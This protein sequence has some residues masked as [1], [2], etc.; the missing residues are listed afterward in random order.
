[1]Q[2]DPDPRGKGDDSETYGLEPEAAAPAASRAPSPSTT[3]AARTPPLEDDDDSIDM[4]P[5]Q[6]GSGDGGEEDG[7]QD[8]G[9]SLPP[10]ISRP[11]APTPWLVAGGACVALVAISWLAGAEQLTLPVDGKYEELGFGARLAG[12]ART[13]V[14]TPIAT[15]GAV[16]GILGLAFMRQRPVGDV[17]AMFA[18]C[19]AIVTIPM[20]LWLVPTDVRFLKQLLNFA[21]YPLAAGALAVPLFRL[22]P[23]DA[24][25][26]T[27][28]SLVGMALVVLS[29]AVVVWAVGV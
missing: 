20:L 19:L 29:S 2:T 8:D 9:D 6:V 11:A 17:P 10:A 25:L 21:G 1:M 28:L 16:F 7:E 4:D 26:A 27:G 18:K 12:L 15:L 22:P 13:L 14:Y 23:A 24:A 3:P 5:V